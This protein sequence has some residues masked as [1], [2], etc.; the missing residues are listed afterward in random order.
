MVIFLTTKSILLQLV[1]Q[2]S[3]DNIPKLRQSTIS[4]PWILH[5]ICTTL[6]VLIKKWS[7][8]ITASNSHL[9][10]KPVWVVCLVRPPPDTKCSG[11][12]YKDKM[13][14]L[15]MTMF[16]TICY[17]TMILV[18]KIWPTWWPGTL[19]FE[20]LILCDPLEPWGAAIIEGQIY[21]RF[22]YSAQIED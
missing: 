20:S 7:V 22:P 1:C 6:E 18:W 3:K 4:F 12:S 21:A 2:V 13:V 9:Q 8:V 11:L 10:L 17:F 16:I 19:L 15:N 14:H 5:K